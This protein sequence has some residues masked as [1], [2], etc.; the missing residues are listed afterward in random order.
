M[1]LRFASYVRA[2]NQREGIDV[3]A[4]TRAMLDA[5][6]VLASS[7]TLEK[8]AQLLFERTDSL[9][10]FA[11]DES[12]EQYEPSIPAPHTI[13]PPALAPLFPDVHCN[14]S[15]REY[16]RSAMSAPGRASVKGPHYSVIDGKL[17]YTAA[18]AIDTPRG[19]RV[20]CADF[21]CESTVE[22]RPPR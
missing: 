22:T 20:L 4:I 16:F 17:C 11:T 18:I 1:W 19:T 14:W 10:V 6:L 2:T 5:A 7:G 21:P 12:G 13:T 3:G 9:R 8:A 15:R